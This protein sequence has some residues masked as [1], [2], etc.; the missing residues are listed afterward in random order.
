V[1]GAW[2]SRQKAARPTL[3]Q[4][5]ND[6]LGQ[7]IRTLHAASRATYGSP[8]IHAQLHSAGWSCSKQ[9]VERLMRQMGVRGRGKGSRRPLTTAS[10]H[11][12][13]VAE[14]HLHQHFEAQQPNQ[15]WVADI[16]YIATAQGWLYLAAVLDLFSRKI[17]GWAMD[18]SLHSDLVVRALD[19]A[20][21]ARRP[22]PGLLH[23]SDRGSQY[24]SLLYQAH[25]HARHI[26]PSMS[27][28]GNCYD[29][30]VMES[31]F[32]TLKV[33]CVHDQRFASPQAAQQEIF[34]YIEGFYNRSRL[35]SALGYLSPDRFEALYSA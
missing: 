11:T 6:A 5:A 23:H 10:R 31:F 20:L 35:H 17:V 9:R 15:K 27:R 33:E 26:L 30:A 34:R 7:A 14:N 1:S 16:T 4:Q 21:T 28:T 3:R 19:M 29:N 25:L 22:P 2:R 32:A 13:P 24:A 8:R 12:L 18:T